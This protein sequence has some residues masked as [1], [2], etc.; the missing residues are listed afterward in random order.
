MSD[1]FEQ[2]LLRITSNYSGVQHA[3]IRMLADAIKSDKR[4]AKIDPKTLLAEIEDFAT[5]TGKPVHNLKTAVD[6]I[7][8]SMG[9]NM[10]P[11]HL[12]RG[13]GDVLRV[14]ERESSWIKRTA[15]RWQGLP[16]EHKVNAGIWG[17]GALLG[18]FGFARSVGHSV[19]KDE[20]GENHLQWS[21]VGI[22][23][24][25]AAMTAGC[26]YMGVQAVRAGVV[27]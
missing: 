16:T 23:L 26:A 7:H 22:A 21:N 19:H 13:S 10:M 17:A 12:M 8:T 15:Q 5:A 1:I 27:R 6:H 20:H 11:E 24:L 4:F 3:N 18:A 25:Q 14:A 9:N 2:E